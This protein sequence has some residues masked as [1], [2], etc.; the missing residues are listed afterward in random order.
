M[1]YQKSNQN[2]LARQQLERA[3]K[4]SPNNSEAKKALSQLRG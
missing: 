2:G 4:L 3:L 1:A